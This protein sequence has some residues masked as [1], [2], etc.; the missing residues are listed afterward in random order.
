MVR[1]QTAK[2]YIGGRWVAAARP[3]RLLDVL[4]PST[5]AVI[6]CIP[7]GSADDADAAATAA[8]E[9]QPAWERLGAAG[10][11]ELVK[12][13][14]RRVRAASDDLAAIQSAE[15]GKPLGDS[16]G[17]VLAGAGALEQYG[18]LGPLHRG[19]SLQGG[20]GA[21]DAMVHVAYGAA[22]ALV[23]WN[24]PLAI[25]C[26]LLGANLVA[27]NTVAFKPS[28]KTPLSSVRLVELFD[29]LPPG[30]LNL[31]LGDGG[32]G[33]ALVEHPSVDLVLHVGS[34]DT[35][36]HIAGRCAA[37][38]KK[39]V[40]ELGGKDPLIVDEGVD[41]VWA[42]E[43]AAL[44]AFANCGQICTSVERIYVH[45]SVAEP[46]LT[47]LVAQAEQRVVGAPT[48][49]ATTMGPLSTR[50]SVPSS[51]PRCRTRWPRE[52]GCS[53]AVDP[54]LDRGSSTRRPCWPTCATTWPCSRRRRSDPLRPCEWW[55]RSRRR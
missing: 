45:R 25:A 10:R 38:G 37:L 1:M 13:A 17:G 24:D 23:P 50:P 20:W 49:P 8:A 54:A 26:G 53:A 14:A 29:H 47:E 51:M 21:T 3:D 44:G 19:R 22:A 36:R 4:D 11:S 48:D 41:P 18:E 39:A 35:G 6:G 15:G 42:A 28:E 30:V 9:A 31:V 12:E 43:Q 32:A 5:G 46:F 33:A 34:A 55:I 16:K 27:G 52:L 40:L 2:P 7:K